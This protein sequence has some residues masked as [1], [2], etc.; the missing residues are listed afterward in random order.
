M[1]TIESR[2]AQAERKAAQRAAAAQA[3]YGG[4]DPLELL[5]ARLES[6]RARMTPEQLAEA[7]A[8]PDLARKVRFSLE[9]QLAW[10]AGGRYTPASNWRRGSYEK[11][12]REA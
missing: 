7:R 6:I 8:D 11:P 9:R 1:R 2:L 10:A 5:L 4:E 3:W 12:E